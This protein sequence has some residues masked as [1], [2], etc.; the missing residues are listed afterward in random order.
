MYENLTLDLINLQL[1]NC[2]FDFNV[3][4]RHENQESL[5]TMQC[6]VLRRICLLWNVLNDFLCKHYF[7]KE[8]FARP[9]RRQP[10]GFGSRN[11]GACL[12]QVFYKRPIP[13]LNAT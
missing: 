12:S 4:I 2:N 5:A 8:M 11:S 7:H 10:G 3:S 1:K 9:I 13:H 6:V